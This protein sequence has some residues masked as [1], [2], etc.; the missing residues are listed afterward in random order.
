MNRMFGARVFVFLVLALCFACRPATAQK[1]ELPKL[2]LRV[3]NRHFTVGKRIP[4]DYLNVFSDGSV[5]CQAIKF[6]TR[7]KDDVKKWRLSPDEL[8]KLT[9]T[10]SDSE[11]RHLGHDYK[12]RRSVIDSWMEWDITIEQ[13]SYR[14]DITLAFAGGSDQTA[15]PEALGKLGCLILELRRTAYGDDNTA[16][17]TPACTVR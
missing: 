14:Q 17:Y 3:V 5:E 4:L 8:G 13:P 12:L 7:D 2:L 15:L 9:S 10:L 1:S 6:D 11:F 16:Y